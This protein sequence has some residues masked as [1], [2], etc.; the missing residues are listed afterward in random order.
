MVC[1]LHKSRRLKPRK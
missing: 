1:N